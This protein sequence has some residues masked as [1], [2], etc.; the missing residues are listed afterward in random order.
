MDKDL[1]RCVGL[2]LAEGDTKTIAEITFTN[3]CFELVDLFYRKLQS[4]FDADNYRLYV[5]RPSEGSDYNTFD[6]AETSLY[7]DDRA[8]QT[9]YIIRLASRDL[10]EEWKEKVSRVKDDPDM[11]SYILQGFFAGEGSVYEGA[12]KSRR[13]RIS[14]GERDE[15]LEEMM[16]HLGI[17]Y[18]FR[19][20]E[21]SY[22]VTKKPNWDIFEEYEICKLHPRKRE[23]F[24]QIYSS[25]Q[26]EH[27][28]KGE[29]KQNTYEKLTEP[30]Q[31][32]ELAEVFDRSQA[33]LCDVLMELKK[34]GKVTNYKAGSQT[35][36]IRDNQNS[37]IISDVKSNYLELLENQYLKVGQI[38]EHFSVTNN[39]AY[40]NLHRLQ[41]LGL[42]K[43]KDHEWTTTET[44]KQVIVL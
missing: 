32:T 44:G 18:F 5:Y 38:S 16:D 28:L 21:R 10:V 23:K 2:W 25:F 8:T 1:A 24:K 12:R 13:L 43:K 40:K 14:Q 15:F 29:L 37:V 36:W 17:S 4:L 31:T 19:P 7:T 30:Y 39:S 41:E 3:S 26:E 22:V 33:R 9:Y 27:Y 11:Y 35:Y 34:E 42:I 6:G 20:E